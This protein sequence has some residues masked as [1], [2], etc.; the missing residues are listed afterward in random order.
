MAWGVDI[1]VEITCHEIV[2][3]I[4]GQW[5]FGIGFTPGNGEFIAI[6][7]QRL[8]HVSVGVLATHMYVGSCNFSAEI[9]GIAFDHNRTLV[10]F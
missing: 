5:V 1:Q 8:N 2:N 3:K 10:S 6:N 9:V 4:C 7:N